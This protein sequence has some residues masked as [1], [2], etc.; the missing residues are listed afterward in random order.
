M[1]K[2]LYLCLLLW[3]ASALGCGSFESS[4][5]SALPRD[6]VHD[7]VHARLGNPDRV[8]GSGRGFL[9]YDLENGQTVTLVVS[10]DK[11]VGAHVTE[12]PK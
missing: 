11:I 2:I 12:T 7:A 8:S 9:H 3:I 5:D 1:K 6:P 4:R 10:G